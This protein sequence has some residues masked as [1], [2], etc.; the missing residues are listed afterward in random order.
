MITTESG[1]RLKCQLTFLGRN[2]VTIST[3][4]SLGA[5]MHLGFKPNHFTHAII[6]EAGQCV[7]PESVIPISFMSKEGGHVILAGDPMQLGPV[8]LSQFALNRGLGKSLLVRMLERTPYKK[9][10]QYHVQGYD[11]RLVTKL[12]INY[13]SMQSILSCYS[14]LFYDGELESMVSD[15][16]SPE[17]AI[18]DRVREI[19]MC[20]DA[21]PSCG[22]FFI[23]TNGVERQVVDSPSWCNPTEAQQIHLVLMHLYKKGINIDD[24][25]IITPYQQQVKNIRQVL[26]DAGLAAPKIGSVEEFQGQERQ[27]ILISTVRS[28]KK[29]LNK[30]IKFSLGFVKSPKR[31]N[32][33][34][35]RAR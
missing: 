33:S 2:R 30:D 23:G 16:G 9:D 24:V 35:S 17:R 19:F 29:M 3:C 13:R 7:E 1:L 10:D 21:N 26:D 25:G 31:L 34:I 5:L 6:D 28:R 11:P 20:E 32:V 18:L 15:T 22:L 4:S 27:I 14:D 8:V 12:R